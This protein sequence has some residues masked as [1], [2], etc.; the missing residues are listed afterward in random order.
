M[1]AARAD[2]HQG[3]D[4]EELIEE[5]RG[6][7]DD[8]FRRLIE[9]YI[10]EL[11]LHCYRML[12]S[13]HDAEDVVQEVMLRAWRHLK[14]FQGRSSFRGWLYRIATNRCL[15]AAAQARP[16]PG[17]GLGGASIPPPP[18]APEVEVVPLEPYPDALLDKIEASTESPAGRY[19]L[20]ES[21]QL[22]F[23]AT[24]QLLPPRQR[25]VLLLRDV[26]D[27]SPSEIAALLGSTVAGVNS[28]VQRA[29]SSLD[30][31][32]RAGRL[33]PDRA[34]PSSE[35]ERTLVRRF[36][37]AWDAVDI[38]GL[39]TLLK[40]DALLTMPPFP[41]AYRGRAAIAEFFATVPA[42][43]A[44][45]QIRLVPTRANRQPAVAAYARDSARGYFEPYGLMVLSLDGE[46]IAEITG[47][48]DP[49]L[50]PHFGLPERLEE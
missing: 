17:G 22:A 6:G 33:P 1:D 32:R 12:G 49:T 48:A 40:E 7:D 36:I 23:L 42:A 26:L 10:G 30:R 41:L 9:P 34:Q 8:A 37:S 28:A 45:D 24:I 19:D 21:V 47:F 39:V 31:H 43:G 13:L 5:A 29:R 44:L 46:V 3:I 35:V 16:R 50:F 18:N 20:R 14:G 27:W 25:A 15:T 38:E 4:E 2:P 11:H